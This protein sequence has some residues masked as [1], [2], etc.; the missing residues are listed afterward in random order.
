MHPQ[1]KEKLEQRVVRAAEAALAHHHYV[2]ATDVFIGMGLLTPSNLQGWR[3][4]R[5][6][7]LERVM[8]GNLKKIS[9]TM[10]L[11]RQWATAKGLRPSETQ[12]ARKGRS[13]KIDLRFS[14]SG[15]SGIEKN[16]RTH[17]VSPE[18]SDRKRE[19]LEERVSR[20]EDPV[21][22]QILRESK[23]SEC[24]AELLP[25]NML[26]MEAEQPLCLPCAGR[27]DLE[28]LPAGDTALTRRSV[29]YSERHNVVVRFS[30]TRGRYER[31]G[32]L[33]EV[34]ALEKAERECYEDAEQRAGQRARA[35]QQ[36][37]QQDGVFV[38]RLAEHIRML[39]PGCPAEEARAIA[40][41]TG[42][43]GSGRIGRS[44]AARM[45]DEQAL[46][47]AVGAAIR[48][49]HTN[50]DELLSRG[51]DRAFSREQVA[52]KVAEVRAAWL[53]PARPLSESRQTEP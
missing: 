17:Y 46:M 23:C 48:H 10:S 18:L 42:E 15:D 3:T 40:E 44:E 30:R 5:V 43:R 16:Y 24:G 28:F 13:G 33:V 38:T 49:R 51:V 32:V 41:H 26:T 21:V 6:D 31:Q 47:L 20:A 27:G 37:Q 8:Q 45:M 39:Y 14:K 52:G 22:F 7:F 50:Y 12:Y 53:S 4:G 34:A 36:R 19:K 9:A 25:G 1:N 2:S 29:K 35:A 11:F